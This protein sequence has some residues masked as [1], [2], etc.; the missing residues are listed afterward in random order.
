MGRC[1][2]DGRGGVQRAR[3]RAQAAAAVRGSAIDCARDLGLQE[4]RGPLA[5]G[6]GV[7][8]DRLPQLHCRQRGEAPV[9]L[10]QVQPGRSTLHRLFRRSDLPRSTCRS[11]TNSIN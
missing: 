9:L 6:Q 5:G 7:L 10:A 11:S 1:T 4:A 3:A 2:N 8:S